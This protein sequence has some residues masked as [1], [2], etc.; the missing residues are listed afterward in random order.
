MAVTVVETIGMVVV[1]MEVAAVI[2][3]VIVM[4]GIVVATVR[5]THEPRI[6]SDGCGDESS[7][8]G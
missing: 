5:V 1:M 2:D 6:G 8:G 4:V 7:S 3:I